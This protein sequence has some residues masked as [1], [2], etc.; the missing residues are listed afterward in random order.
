MKR[1]LP[2]SKPSPFFSWERRREAR[3]AEEGLLFF[4]LSVSS[5][6]QIEVA[7]V[8]IAVGGFEAP[9]RPISRMFECHMTF[10]KGPTGFNIAVICWLFPPPR[11]RAE[12]RFPFSSFALMILALAMC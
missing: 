9:P 12:S 10:I 5:V 3:V 1:D 7:G 11:D 4:Y 8:L 2:E 6:R